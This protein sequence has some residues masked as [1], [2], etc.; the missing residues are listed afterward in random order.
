MPYFYL[1]MSVLTGSSLSIFGK[2]YNIKNGNKKD[3]IVLYNFLLLSSIL[4]C[5]TISFI[6]DFSFDAGVLIYSLLFALCF[7][8]CNVGLIN[9]LKHGPATLTNLFVGLSLIGTTIWGLLFWGAELSVLVIIGL[10]LVVMSISL[11]IYSN[12]KDEKT[13]SLKWIFYVLL[14]FF[15]NAGCTIV[16]RTQQI[17]YE[18]KHSN[19]LMFF[20]LLF[21]VLAYLVVYL[22]SD[23]SQ[24]LEIIKTSWYAPVLAGI[25]NFLLNLFVILLVFTNLSS[26]LIY[27]VIGV[28]ELAV[29][30][31]FSLIV[32]KEKMYWWQW[33][34]VFVGAVATVLLSI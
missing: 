3:S 19:M 4:L 28:G 23:K 21:S 14:A 9:A 22:K 33:L 30:A 10:I 2:I 25:F 26:S 15:G 34:G 5:W 13:I 1:L 18:G 7:T 12:K 8:G 17:I 29:V 32:F 16:Q 6:L 20:A 27:P 11:C 24:S 31:I